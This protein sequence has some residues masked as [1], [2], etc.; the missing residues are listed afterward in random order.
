MRLAPWM[1]DSFTVV[2]AILGTTISPYVLFWQSSQEVEEIGR[3]P[4]AEPLKIDPVQA[5]PEMQRIRI[6]WLA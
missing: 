3:K 1:G 4:E 6:R 5:K 2:V